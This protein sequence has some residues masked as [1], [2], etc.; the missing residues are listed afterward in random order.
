MPIY[1]VV[2]TAVCV[3]IAWGVHRYRRN[4]YLNKLLDSPLAP[5]HVDVLVANVP[6]YS[7][8]PKDLQ[9]VLQ[10]C[11]NYFLA[12]KVF[13]GCDDFR[14]TDEVRLTVA[15]NACILVL[16]R[17]KKH[18]PG[19][20]TILVYPHTYVAKQ[21]RYDGLVEI[22]ED[23]SRAGES[24]HRGPVVLSWADTVHGSDNPHDGHNVILHE[25]AHKLDEENTLMDGL[26][27]LR[28]SSHYKEWA[29]VL[30][31]E[32]AEFINR[33]THGKNDVIDEYGAVSAVEFFAVATE[34]FFEKSKQMKAKLPELY[35][36]FRTFY[37]L[38]PA[39][40]K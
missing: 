21:V 16:N 36:Q 14:I 23:S 27:V 2:G 18:F 15:G 40:W 13:V 7:R 28:E 29:S 31:A 9:L 25:F 30:T 34:S 39:E 6:L 22:H 4:Q 33:V 26:P 10:G 17:D 11:V 32:Y 8:L 1:I 5:E 19:F 20:E 37:G 12:T 35:G 24:W 3:L 38:D